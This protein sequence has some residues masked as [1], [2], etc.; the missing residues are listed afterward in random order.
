METNS[1]PVILIPAARGANPLR[2]SRAQFRRHPHLHTGTP[3]HRNQRVHTEPLDL[4]SHQITHPRLGHSEQLCG[5]GLSEVVILNEPAEF[6]HEVGPHAKVLG[7][8][9]WESEIAEHVSTG[10][11]HF[12]GQR[13][14]LLPSPQ[15]H[16]EG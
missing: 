9:G 12:L 7:F 6:D 15:V 5:L 10:A 16:H 13:G 14:P 11:L 1:L 2:Y 3:Q 8:G 4:P